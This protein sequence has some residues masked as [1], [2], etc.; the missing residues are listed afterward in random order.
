MIELAH[1]IQRGWLD[2]GKELNIDVKPYFQYRYNLHIVDGIIFLQDRIVVP[3][4][5]REAF[6]KKIHDAHLGV[7]KSKLLEW[8]L[9][10]W[11]NWNNDIETTCQNFTLCRENQSMPPNIP[12]YQVK[13]NSP[14]EIYGIDV[15][16]ISGKS[17]IVCVDYYTCC[18]FERK[19]QSLHSTDVID[20]LKSIFCDIGAPDKIISNNARYFM[21]EE[22][23]EFMMK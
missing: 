16:D 2:T 7:V 14:G 1:T 5:L 19:L 4:G 11:P 6:L 9:V 20:V 15:T 21:S 12:K 18:I 8:T 10:Y 3:M 13:A 17:H 23:E 22:F